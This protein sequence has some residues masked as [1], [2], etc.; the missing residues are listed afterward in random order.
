M[1]S[2]LPKKLTPESAVH[3][4]H[5]SSPVGKGDVSDFDA[6]LR[7]LKT[8][9]PKTTQFAV[10]RGELD[11]RYLDGS[12][13][14]R[15][16][17]FRDALRGADWLCPVYGGT[18][19]ADVIRKL[20]ERDHRLFAAR[21]PIVNGFSDSTYLINYLYFRVGLRT[22]HYTN[23]A[24]LFSYDTSGQFFGALTG[25]TDELSFLDPK[26]RWLTP[27]P[28]KP[29]TGTAIGGNLTTFRDL[30][31]V[32]RIEMP[33]WRPYILFIEDLDLDA[34]MFHRILIALDQRGVF[35]QIRALVVGRVDEPDYAGV[36]KK[37]DAI[38]GRREEKPHHYVEYLLSETIAARKK[39]GDPLHILKVENF[40]HNVKKDLMVVPIGADTVLQPDRT[41]EFH[42]PFVS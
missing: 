29:V 41:V 34:E 31:D 37:F 10:K 4:V 9:H 13:R 23:A 38:F 14:E 27:L 25:A 7:K 6:V 26:S 39:A 33:T 3:L 24:G 36:A 2:I 40:G 42:G 17:R 35:K 8:R 19:C 1:R 22:F 11:P 21:R 30:L 5:L 32:S 16:Q 28:R 18:G 20:S 15:L 12:E